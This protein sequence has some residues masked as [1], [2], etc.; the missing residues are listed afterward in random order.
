MESIC[1]SQLFGAHARTPLP[2]S[3]PKLYMYM[4]R[5]GLTELAHCKT[6]Q[7]HCSLP[8]GVHCKKRYINV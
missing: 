4:A 2:M 6:N 3:M 8:S 1:I 5:L 7:L